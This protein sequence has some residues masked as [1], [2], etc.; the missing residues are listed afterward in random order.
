MRK[1]LINRLEDKILYEPNTGCWI[2]TAAIQA[3][4]YAK[5]K[6]K[7]AMINAHRVSYELYIGQIPEGLELDHTCRVP[8]CV[9]PKHLEPVTN[10]ENARRRWVK[11]YRTG[12]NAGYVFTS[13]KERAAKVAE[14]RSLKW[15]HKK[16]AQTLGISVPTVD[17]AMA[18]ARALLNQGGGN[19]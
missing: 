14:L 17:R 1:S 19:G 2:W 4:G 11:G 15:S 13:I 10:A 7:G 5:F 9:N 6:V 18:I 8:S 16:I 3:D 12:N